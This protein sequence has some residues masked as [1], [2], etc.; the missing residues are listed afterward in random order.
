MD[1]ISE[2]NLRRVDLNTLLVLVVLVRERSVTRAAKRLFLGQ[3][4]VSLA[5]KRLR[6][7]FRDPLFVRTSQ[8]MEPTPR[9]LE[10]YDGL[11]QGLDAIHHTVFEGSSFDPAKATTAIRLG[12]TDDLEIVLAPIL[13]DHLAREAPRVQ[14]VL[15]PADVHHTPAMLDDGDVQLALTSLPGNLR[16]WHRHQVLAHEHFVCL[17]SPRKVKL[18]RRVTLERYLALPHVLVSAVGAS[19][20]IVDRR[21]AELGHTRRIAMVTSR[22]SS[23]PLVLRRMPALANVPSAIARLY[24]EKLGLARSPLPFESP[25]F[26]LALVWHARS[27][28]DRA[29]R[30]VRELVVRS[31]LQQRDGELRTT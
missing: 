19:S 4:A 8:G 17:Y 11:S 5:L 7:Q 29:V 14:L 15:R 23:L 31:T 30:W 13:L 10:L 16:S 24:V 1:A 3:P 25:R 18:S 21:L 20:G 26:P 28:G 22:F 6:E 2:S 12:V 9:A 27:D